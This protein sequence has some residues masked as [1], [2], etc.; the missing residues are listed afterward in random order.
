MVTINRVFE[1]L[2]SESS[3][4]MKHVTSPDLTSSKCLLGFARAG[5]GM[6]SRKAFQGADIADSVCRS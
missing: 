2:K 4:R 1:A 3:W 5:Q 6:S